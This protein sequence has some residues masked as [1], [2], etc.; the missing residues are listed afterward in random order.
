MNIET[1]LNSED[2]KEKAKLRHWQL[3]DFDYALPKSL[4]AQKPLA[5]RTK[6]RLLSLDAITG[7]CTHGKFTDV[8]G[9]FTP[10]DVLVLNDTRVMAARLQGQ[11]TSG[12]A[13]EVLVS[14][15]LSDSDAWVH[16]HTH[17]K[18]SLGSSI[19]VAGMP[20]NIVGQEH[21]LYQLRLVDGHWE[22]LMESHGE[23]PL[24]PYI[25]HAPDDE[26]NT[27]YQ[28]VYAKN[29]GAIAAPTAGL[30]F[31]QDILKVIESQGVSIEYITLHVGAGTFQPV[32]TDDITRHHMHKESVD[33]SEEVCKRVNTAKKD[34]HKVIA[35]G[36]TVVR[37]LESAERA[38]VLYAYRGQ[39]DKFIYPGYKFGIIDE[40][41]TNFHLPK[42][43]LLM[44]VSAL[45]GYEAVM[46]AYHEAVEQHYRFFSYGD[47]MYIG[48]VPK[49]N[50]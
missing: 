37:A 46:A 48:N 17:R 28:T 8:L 29:Q 11:K 30:H 47:A 4:I 15:V 2:E 19:L 7:R 10:G 39:T 35:V 16:L 18:K 44:L 38:G 12:G 6:S 14:E 33:V 41:I 22:R 23:L 9:Y 13:L 49:E 31:D 36:T 5:T 34:G 45:G 24:P 1:L 20:A 43:T 50:S 32:R 42:S 25:E 3:S 26:D 40:L 21:G 27:R